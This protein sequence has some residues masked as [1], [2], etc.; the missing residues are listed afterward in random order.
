MTKA[1]I[2]RASLHLD[3]LLGLDFYSGQPCE[4]YHYAALPVGAS[5]KFIAAISNANGNAERDQDYICPFSGYTT[6]I[7]KIKRA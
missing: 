4:N 7:V 2:R 6:E 1:G 3:C 5:E